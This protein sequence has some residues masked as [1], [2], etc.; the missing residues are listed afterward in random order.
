MQVRAAVKRELARGTTGAGGH[1]LDAQDE[2]NLVEEYDSEDEEAS[3]QKAEQ[4]EK[5]DYSLRVS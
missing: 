5:E 2:E 4:E 1:D 3:G